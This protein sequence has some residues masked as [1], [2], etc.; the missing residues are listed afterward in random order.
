M[1]KQ[2]TALSAG[3]LLTAAML[4]GCM[5]KQGDLGNKN[6]RTNSVRTDANGN[7]VRDKR[8]AVDQ[9]NEMNRVGG[10]RLNSNNLVGSHKNY[11]MEM[12]E[13]IADGVARLEA[14]KSSYVLL[15]D[16]NAY[17]AV[18]LHEGE[19]A[20]DPKT[21]SR[22][23]SGYMGKEGAR[24]S[25]KMSALA[26][27]Q[28]MLTD[29]LKDEIAR[30]VKRLKPDLEQVYVSANPDFV[31]RLNA[32]MNDV[33]LGHPI[34]SFIA[35]FNAMAERIFSAPSGESGK[36]VKSAGMNKKRILYD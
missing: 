5:E 23:N 32:Y 26:T 29:Q 3:M 27:G 11:R 8:F 6:I 12:S 10:R 17:V 4:T 22:T 35:E 7:L 13:K 19:P 34:Q 9:M 36:P 1:R 25:R 14:V 2:M 20:G 28:H 24:M 18:S 16:H 15:T 30:E 33:K 21:M 31:G